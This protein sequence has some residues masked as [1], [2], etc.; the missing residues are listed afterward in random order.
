MERKPKE[1]AEILNQIF[2]DQFNYRHDCAYRLEWSDLRGISG[3]LK[4]SNDFFAEIDKA[5]STLN[6]TLMRV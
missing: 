6:L 3:K 4:V 2:R 1:V 5:L